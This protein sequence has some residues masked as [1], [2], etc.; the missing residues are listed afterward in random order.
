MAAPSATLNLER[1]TF[2]A[3]EV[4]RALVDA[5]WS[6]RRISGSHHI[7]SRAGCPSLPVAVHGGKLRRDVVLNVM[8]QAALHTSLLET[9]EDVSAP[10]ESSHQP[11][12]TPSLMASDAALSK[13]RIEETR[14]AESSL[15]EQAAFIEQ[16]Q[17]AEAS[18]REELMALQE[19]LQ[20]AQLELLEGD[21]A[22]VDS[23]LTR[24]LSDGC[25]HLCERCGYVFV[26][27][28]L[29]FLATALCSI[30]MKSR[31]VGDTSSQ[32]LI[33]RSF[34]TCKQLLSLRERRDDAKALLGSLIS[35]V[36]RS[37]GRDLL[38]LAMSQAVEEFKDSDLLAHACSSMSASESASDLV[39]RSARIEG[40]KSRAD[41]NGRGC[42]VESYVAAKDRFQVC[43]DGSRENLLVKRLNL[44]L[45]LAEGQSARL[46]GGHSEQLDN[47]NQ[48]LLQGFG[49]IVK[50]ARAD[51][52]LVFAVPHDDMP[53]PR[54][55]IEAI[56]RA[57]I[58]HYERGHLSEAC[59]AFEAIEF[60]CVQYASDFDEAQQQ[61]WRQ[62]DAIMPPG[63]R[64]TNMRRGIGASNVLGTA[65]TMRTLSHFCL[66]MRAAHALAAEKLHWSRGLGFSAAHNGKATKSMREGWSA[67]LAAAELD[68]AC[69]RPLNS[70]ALA[71]FMD[72]FF[73]GMTYAAQ[74]SDALRT[75]QAIMFVTH[76]MIDPVDL[77][78]HQCNQLHQ[79]S[80]ILSRALV[81][82]DDGAGGAVAH[83]R[84][85]GALDSNWQDQIARSQHHQLR[86]QLVKMLLWVVRLHQL[87]HELDDLVE[88][89]ITSGGDG[90]G[91]FSARL[92]TLKHLD[93]Y[94]KMLLMT[95]CQARP[96]STLLDILTENL[97]F[98]RVLD[99]HRY[100]PT[101]GA[102]IS[103]LD[104][105]VPMASS[106]GLFV[107]DMC[108][109]LPLFLRWFTATDA[110]RKSLAV[111][112]GLMNTLK[113]FAPS[114][115]GGRLAREQEQI[116]DASHDGQFSAR[117]FEMLELLHK[118]DGA[119]LQWETAADVLLSLAGSAT[120]RQAR[121]SAEVQ[122]T[123][124][125]ICSVV[126]S[127]SAR[128]SAP[129][130]R[131][132]CERRV[133]EYNAL[134]S[135]LDKLVHALRASRP[136]GD[137]QHEAGFMYHSQVESMGARMPE[138]TA[139]DLHQLSMH[140]V[141]LSEL[142]TEVNTRMR[143][144]FGGNFPVLVWVTDCYEY[145]PAHA[146]KDM[147]PIQ[148]NQVRLADAAR[149][150]SRA[151]ADGL[152]GRSTPAA[153]TP[154]PDA[155]SASEPPEGSNRTD[156]DRPSSSRR[157]GGKKGVKK[158]AISADSSTIE[159]QD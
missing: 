120:S 143:E 126:S 125:R 146:H 77:I 111:K 27:D 127:V 10:S 128:F 83:G 124:R 8:R 147:Q 69:T 92:D 47:L 75:P 109:H 58:V 105:G 98:H 91:L 22:A 155:R 41:L 64:E 71:S 74:H 130:A 151:V 158:S 59:A 70:T 88:A 32:Q 3:A 63:F 136:T 104:P 96:M 139:Y 119:V 54:E 82:Y 138:W 26:A 28:A 53:W 112:Y 17:K 76:N 44:R 15:E 157:R 118:L 142:A 9:A 19:A 150:L 30:A 46:V 107:M 4:F 114:H 95:C 7:F 61:Q 131:E 35:W 43:V 2:R 141:A 39:G 25:D 94:L 1:G 133:R 29:F 49:F 18:K 24:L 148:E 67:V 117:A 99:Y 81:G 34:S 159:D 123:A 90:G 48:G 21:Y 37:Y 42:T 122:Q 38:T 106:K 36:Y 78:L 12:G 55:G 152:V 6:Q 62:I 140:A 79:G 129:L 60:V 121:R 84:E 110:E 11:V 51:E 16:A 85:G 137:T 103:K 5:G 31:P 23:R 102:Q 100:R 149:V 40:L 135:L 66:L 153:A 33:S 52:Q 132:L 45:P 20:A 65:V 116:R 87:F 73:E 68:Q 144:V 115:D 113:G 97:A 56:A 50:L 108:N 145:D 13:Q 154:L 80:K 14:W 72:L 93:T 101:L 57:A 134:L 86:Q 156:S 89:Q